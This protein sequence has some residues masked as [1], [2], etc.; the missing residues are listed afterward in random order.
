MTSY[1]VA[2]LYKFVELKDFEN[3]KAPLH[4]FCEELGIRGSILL[5]KEGI[6]GTVSGEE[7]AVKKLLAHLQSDPRLS[8]LSHKESWAKRIPFRRM[9][10][11]L[12]VEIVRMGVD[13]ID[14]NSKVGTYVPP[15][16]WNK[17]ISDPDTVVIDTRNDYETILGTFKGAVDPDTQNFQQF[18]EWVKNSKEV[19]GPN[20]SK[21][22]AMF[23]TGGIRCEKASALMLEEGYEEVYHL[24]GGI[25]NYLEKIPENE[26]LWKGECFV[27]DDRVSVDHSLEAG[28]GHDL[29]EKTKDVL[30]EYMINQEKSRS[31]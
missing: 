19:N 2:A 9:R 7:E 10:V 15:E 21:K 11:R 12:K 29:P 1:L 13:G 23:C 8:D 18:P 26:S 16:E 27:F 31:S 24:Q 25:L 17:L 22:I 5:A 3:M 14:P 6:N 30:S 28:W 4:A 20:K